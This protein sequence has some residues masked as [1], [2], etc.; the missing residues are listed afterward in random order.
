QVSEFSSQVVIVDDSYN[1]NPASMKAGIEYAHALAKHKKIAV[2]WAILGDMLELGERGEEYH[3]AIARYLKKA[4]FSELWAVGDLMHYTVEEAQRRGI[5]SRH[6][7][8]LDELL[9]YLSRLRVKRTLIFVKGSRAM[10]MEKVVGALQER[11]G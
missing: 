2:Q 8:S 11:L 5:I 1:A 4:H 3:R 9:E 7:S 10:R 6:F